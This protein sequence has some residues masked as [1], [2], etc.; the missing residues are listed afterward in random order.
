MAERKGRFKRCLSVLF[1][2]DQLEEIED[3]ASKRGKTRQWIR[4]R[5]ENGYFT[6]IVR[7]L[8]AEDTPAYHH[9][10]RMKFEDFT[11]ILRE[12]VADI[13]PRQVPK[14]GHKVISAAERLTLTLRFLATGETFR[15]L[16][17]QFRISRAA[18]SYIVKEVCQAIEKRLGPKFLAL[19]SSQEEWQAIAL[20][21]EERWNFPNCLGAI[22]GKHIV[23]EPPAGSG[24]FYYNYKNT[25][26]IVLMAIAGPDFE[27]LYADIGTNGRVSDG[28]V[29]NKCS[30]SQAIEGGTISLP[31]P[32]CLPH[33]VQK[34]P[35]IFVA[36]DAFA[37][38]T[39]LMKPYP[40]KGLDAEKRV[41]NYHHSRARRI[42]ENLFGIVAN[43]WRV[44]RGVIQ[45]APSSIESLVIAALMP[46][47]FL[48][49]SSSRNQYCPSGLLDTEL[50]NGERAEGLWR[51]ETPGNSFLPLA[52]PTTGHNASKD[53]KLVQD[54]FKAYFVNEG[55]VEWQWDKI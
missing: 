5:Q 41:Y 30:L 12:I 31:P 29:W 55:A 53:A 1:V 21:F 17:F 45:L 23:M 6:N 3:R 2:L 47:N 50:S 33:G 39:N 19:P 7:E 32:K 38:K 4:R 51:Q 25:N 43:R 10:M 49:K 16:S 8:A 46:H 34:L 36:D 28:G 27:C 54:T 11:A 37:L 42:V 26:S 13:T 9:M 52:V 48:R 24:S 44:F 15:S 35:H 40:Q 20:K 14:G 22:D 18:I